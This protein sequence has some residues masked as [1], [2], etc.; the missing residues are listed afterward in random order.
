MENVKIISL[1]LGLSVSLSLVN[2]FDISNVGKAIDA[3]KTFVNNT[4]D[5][6]SGKRQKEEEEKKKAQA[7][8]DEKDIK[9]KLNSQKCAKKLITR[10]KWHLIQTIEP[11]NFNY[12]LINLR[13]GTLLFAK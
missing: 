6:V 2:A 12:F 5:M 11:K 8:A 7:E 9:N 1:A 4:S 3:T 13:I 10:T